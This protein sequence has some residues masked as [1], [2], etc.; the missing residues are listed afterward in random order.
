MAELLVE[1]I[2][3][4]TESVDAIVNRTDGWSLA[5]LD[6]AAH[7]AVLTSLDTGEPVDLL[8]ALDQ[9]VAE[10]DFDLLVTGNGKRI[11]LRIVVE[12]TLS[13]QVD[14]PVSKPLFPAVAEHFKVHHQCS[15]QSAPL[16]GCFWLRDLIH[17]CKCS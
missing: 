9:V 8:G 5:E 3:S 6:E 11:H 14:H 15:N 4:S 12:K 13:R 17:F 10:Q 1:R 16:E 7:L 2:G